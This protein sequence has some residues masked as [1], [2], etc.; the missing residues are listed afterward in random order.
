MNDKYRKKKHKKE[1]YI[2]YIVC[3]LSVG[4]LRSVFFLVNPFI[5][6]I[7]VLDTDIAHCGL[8]YGIEIVVL[9]TI[10]LVVHF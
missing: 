5:G 4:S 2:V 3:G 8:I 7:L 1:K 9:T 6:F 10:V